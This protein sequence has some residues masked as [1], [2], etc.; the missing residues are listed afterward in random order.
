MIVNFKTYKINQDTRKLVRILILIK[1]KNTNSSIH[2]TIWINGDG[3]PAGIIIL[4]NNLK[5]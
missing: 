4:K 2:T 3:Y 5:K 1:K